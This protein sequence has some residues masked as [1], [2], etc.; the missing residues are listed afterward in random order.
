VLLYKCCGDDET[1]E[2]ELNAACSMCGRV[3]KFIQC[4]L[5]KSKGRSYLGIPKHR[6]QNTIKITLEK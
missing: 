5:G 4:L 2:S 1:K 6:W 3:E